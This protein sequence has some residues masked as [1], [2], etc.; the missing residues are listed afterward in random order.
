MEIME[1]VYVGS[2]FDWGLGPELIPTQN[3]GGKV[4]FKALL[5]PDEIFLR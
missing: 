3:V 5:V 1:W 2:G 4:D